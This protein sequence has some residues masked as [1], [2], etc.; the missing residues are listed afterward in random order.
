MCKNQIEMNKYEV[1]LIALN[2][3][4]LIYSISMVCLPDI[5]QRIDCLPTVSEEQCKSY[6]YGTYT[7]RGGYCGCCPTCYILDD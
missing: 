1:F 7:E 2:I 6:P 4:S 5:C 3:L